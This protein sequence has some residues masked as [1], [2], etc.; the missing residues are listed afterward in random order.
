M[1]IPSCNAQCRL[2]CIKKTFIKISVVD[3]KWFIPDPDPAQN[4]PSSG[5][6]QNSIIKKNLSTICHFLFHTRYYSPTVH[7]VNNSKRNNI[8]IICSFIFCWIHAEPDP[9]HWLK[10]MTTLLFYKSSFLKYSAAFWCWKIYFAEILLPY[11]WK[12]DDSDSPRS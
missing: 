6:R 8:F 9:Q 11:Y 3:P 2:L 5:S 7:K 12:F 4:F 10:L 1:W